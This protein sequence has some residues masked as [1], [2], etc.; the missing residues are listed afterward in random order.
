MI[1]AVDGPSASGKGSV[2]RRLAAHFGLPYLDTGV[3]YRA[4]ARDMIDQ[5]LPLDDAEAAARAARN[6]NLQA[7]DDARLR[8][9]YMG[10]AAS[11]VAALPDVRQALL[12]VQRAFAHRSGGAVLDGRDIGTV[13]CPDADVKLYITASAEARAQRRFEELRALGEDVEAEEVHQDILKRDRRDQ[14]RSTAPLRKADDAHLL[15][16]TNL[17]IEQAFKAALGLIN[18]AHVPKRS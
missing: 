17:D 13:V 16:T 14:E 12:E 6:V 4:V 15:D 11:R 1:I 7:L 8:E 18:A 5:G 10:E 9:R 3:L 2:S